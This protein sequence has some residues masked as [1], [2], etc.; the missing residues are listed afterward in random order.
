METGRKRHEK[1]WLSVGHTRSDERQG[2]GPDS[3]LAEERL[4]STSPRVDPPS[5]QLTFMGNPD[6]EDGRMEGTQLEGNEYGEETRIWIQQSRAVC[7]ESERRVL[8]TQIGPG[9]IPT[10]VMQSTAEN[11]Q[12]GMAKRNQ[13]LP[14][15]ATNCMP[16][17]LSAVGLWELHATHANSTSVESA[18][19]RLA[20]AGVCRL[21]RQKTPRC[22]GPVC[23]L[24]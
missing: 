7:G 17:P 10:E 6:V 21:R 19:A 24:L 11:L 4:G 1:R 9:L 18:A 14:F 3:P 22:G 8:A 20:L 13:P 12:A 5:E 23:R 2:L 15:K 16:S